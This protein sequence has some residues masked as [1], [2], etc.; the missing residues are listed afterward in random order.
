[1]RLIFHALFLPRILPSCHQDALY[2]FDCTC[3]ENPQERRC[4]NTKT[5]HYARSH[6]NR[7]SARDF[8]VVFGRVVGTRHHPSSDVSSVGRSFKEDSLTWDEELESDAFDRP[9]SETRHAIVGA[10]HVRPGCV[11]GWHLPLASVLGTC[12]LPI[13]SWLGRPTHVVHV[14]LSSHR[15]FSLPAEKKLPGCA[16]PTSGGHCECPTDEYDGGVDE[17]M[18]AVDVPQLPRWAS[19]ARD[20][21][22]TKE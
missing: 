20:Q 6:G 17:R 12:H 15:L 21:L 14:P 4:T 22:Q 13:S 1:M 2:T 11:H 16:P 3:H 7:C 8:L 9:F 18:S 5:P 19:C 10:L